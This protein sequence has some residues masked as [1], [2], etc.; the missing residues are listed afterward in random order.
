MNIK[1]KFTQRRK[2]SRVADGAVKSVDVDVNADAYEDDEDDIC[3]YSMAY[4]VYNLK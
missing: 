2:N 4:E 1:M 3:V